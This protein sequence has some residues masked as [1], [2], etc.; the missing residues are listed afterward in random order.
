M[1]FLRG[2]D[3]VLD[4]VRSVHEKLYVPKKK[5]VSSRLRLADSTFFDV[6]LKNIV[7]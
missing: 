6:N 2:Q 5:W 4:A 7:P 3:I 1:K